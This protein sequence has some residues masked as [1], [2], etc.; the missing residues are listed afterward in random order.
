MVAQTL[1]EDPDDYMALILSVDAVDELDTQWPAEVSTASGADACGVRLDQ[2]GSRAP[3]SA[4]TSGL[5]GT[6]LWSRSGS[7]AWTATASVLL[8]LSR[9]LRRRRSRGRR[10]PYAAGR[11]RLRPLLRAARPLLLWRVVGFCGTHL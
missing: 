6:C 1:P 7:P 4:R 11:L 9:D 8:S 2:T 5:R 3:I 10:P